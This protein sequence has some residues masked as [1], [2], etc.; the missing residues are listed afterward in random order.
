MLQSINK[1]LTVKLFHGKSVITFSYKNE[2]QS[3][4]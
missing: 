1:S 2:A 3:S 4:P